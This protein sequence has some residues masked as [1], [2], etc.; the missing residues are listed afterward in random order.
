LDLLTLSFILANGPAQPVSWL[1]RNLDLL[2]LS[3]ILANG[4]AQPVSWLTWNSL[5]S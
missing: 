1:T 2:T 5:R 3:F 4:P